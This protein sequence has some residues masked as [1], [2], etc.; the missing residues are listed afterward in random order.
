MIYHLIYLYIIFISSYLYNKYI[1][2]N[3]V[4][5]ISYD[6]YNIFIISLLLIIQ[7]DNITL[8]YDF[9][10]IDIEYK[11]KLREIDDDV[12]NIYNKIKELEK[13]NSNLL[14]LITMI[15]NKKNKNYNIKQSRSYDKLNN[16][17]CNV[18]D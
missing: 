4:N 3:I 11:K 10:K 18:S 9:N 16:L 7:I 1:L 8:L 12:S 6:Y 5:I 13:N 14:G 15:N 2:T 17:Y